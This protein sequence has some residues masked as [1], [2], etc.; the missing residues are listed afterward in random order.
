MTDAPTTT[1]NPRDWDL[2]ADRAQSKRF[3]R[4]PARSEIA[5]D[6][7][8]AWDDFQ[9]RFEKVR[10]DKHMLKYRHRIAGGF[11]GLMCSPRLAA[12]LTAGGKPAMAQQGRPGSFTAIDHELID[13]ILSFDSGHWG[14]L[15]NHV[16]FAIASGITVD[17]VR[18]VRDGRDETLPPEMQ[19]SVKFIRATRDGTITDDLWAAMVAQIGSERGVVELMYLTLHLLMH[20]RL[21]QAFDEVQILPDELEDLLGLLERGEYPLP[22]VAH[23][24][25]A[26]TR[27]VP[28]HP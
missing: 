11:F 24:G 1:S 2:L 8:A 15:A 17:Q 23:A 20:V 13:L 12:Q 10:D 16:P 27:P 21:I 22:E 5:P 3:P 14:L 9:I 4:V 6:E 18:A 28:A 19:C 7:L 25:P 26:E